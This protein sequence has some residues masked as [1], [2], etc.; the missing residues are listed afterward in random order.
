MRSTTRVTPMIMLRLFACMLFLSITL[1]VEGFIIKN[2]TKE[3]I[4]ISEIGITPVAGD[5]FVRKTLRTDI[6]APERILGSVGYVQSVN[7]MLKGVDTAIYD[8]P[9]H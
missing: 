1:P 4:V 3:Y 9:A 6:V 7:V 2:M 8:L 5:I